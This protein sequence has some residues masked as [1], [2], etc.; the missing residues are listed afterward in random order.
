MRPITPSNWNITR[1]YEWY[2]LRRSRLWLFKPN[3]R[4]VSVNVISRYF[5]FQRDRQPGPLGTTPDLMIQRFQLGRKN[6]KLT[7]RLRRYDAITLGREWLNASLDNQLFVRPIGN[8]N[9]R[10][11]RRQRRNL[12]RSILG[13]GATGATRVAHHK[14][15]SVAIITLLQYVSRGQ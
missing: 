9:F 12:N 3:S 5:R 15:L 11:L 4:L 8:G 14:F 13:N 6:A 1:W 10:G 7:G 2:E